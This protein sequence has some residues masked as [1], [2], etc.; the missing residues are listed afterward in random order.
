PLLGFTAES[1]AEQRT[2]EARFDASVRR[3]DIRDWVERLS[4]RPHHVGSPYGKEN[5]EWMAG[6]FCPWGYDTRIEPFDVLFPTPRVRQV[7]MLTPR[8]FRAALAEPALAEDA[9]SGQAS[10]QLPT[11]NAYSI[12]GDVTGELVYVNYGVPAD[13]EELEKRGIAGKGKMGIAR[14]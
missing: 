6:L 1:S 11:Y 8:P 7:E 12:D 13:Y 5:A 9:T 4:K 3:S 10:E 2:L 14:Y